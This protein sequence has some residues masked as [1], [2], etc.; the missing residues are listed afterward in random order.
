MSDCTWYSHLSDTS[1]IKAYVIETRMEIKKSL[2]ITAKIK[3]LRKSKERCQLINR[4]DFIDTISKEKIFV[5][6]NIQNRHADG[7]MVD[8]SN[9]PGGIR[10]R[11]HFAEKLVSMRLKGITYTKS[12]SASA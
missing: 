8:V 11:Q 1:N 2:N 9:P 6:T 4:N 7:L 5:E 12:S 3:I 10:S